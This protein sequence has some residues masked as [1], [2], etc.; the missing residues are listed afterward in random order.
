MFYEG[1]KFPVA[2]F[3]TFEEHPSL[4]DSLHIFPFATIDFPIFVTHHK[5]GGRHGCLEILLQGL[6]VPDILSFLDNENLVFCH[7]GIALGGIDY[8][9]GRNI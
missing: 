7:H 5:D 4:L 2:Q 1:H 8:L 3:F 6:C 9:R